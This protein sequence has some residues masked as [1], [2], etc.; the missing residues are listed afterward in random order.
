MFLPRFSLLMILFLCVL[1]SAG[2]VIS[3]PAPKGEPLSNDY[4]VT[5]NGK[6]VPV[7]PVKSQHRDKKYSIAY[8]D[9]E[10]PV[11]VTIKTSRPLNN[12]VVLPYKYG[13]KPSVNGNAATFTT[14]RPFDISFEPTGGDSPLL[15]FSNSLEKDVPQRDDKNVIYFGPGVHN[16]VGGLIKLKSNQTLYIAGGAVVK[17]GIDATGDNI[18]IMG[19][20]II[21]GSDWDHN[22]GPNDFMIN[23]TDCNNLIIKDVILKGS[24]YWTV[25]PQRCDRVLIDHIRLAG[26]RVGNDDGVNPCNSSN[27]TIKNCFFRTDDDAISPKGITRA[28][29]EQTS[30]PVENVLVENCT[31]WVDF[32]NVFRIATESSCPAI[33]NFTAR[34]I[35]VI[36]FPRRKNVQI[37]YLHPTGNMPM[38]NL[39]FENIRIN[40]ESFFNLAKLTPMQPLVGTRS[41]EKPRPNNITLGPGRRGTGSR[42]YGEFVWIHGDGPYIHNVTFRNI[43]TYGKNSTP[44]L[45]P[46]ATLIQGIDEN[47]K[48]SNVIFSNVSLYNK[49]LTAQSPGVKIGPYTNGIT[50]NTTSGQPFVHPGL[51]H[52]AEDLARMKKAVAIRE[53]PVYA[54][55]QR[56]IL[57]PASQYTYTMQGPMSMVGRNPTVGQTVYDSDANAAH[58]NAVMWAITGDKR[59]ADKAIQIVNA[60]SSTLDTITG[61]DA[62]LMAGLGPFKMVNAAE[63]LR[64]TNAGWSE[65]DIKQ[66]EKHFKEVIYPVISHFAPFA[67]GNWDAAAIKTV[68]AIG[69]FC[70][71]RAIYENGLR[72][73]INGCGNGR[74]THYVI[75]EEG[76]AQETGRDQPHTQLGIGL[77]SDC[78]EIAWHQGLDLYSYADNRLLKGFEY[79][80]RYNLGYEVPFTHI[81]DRTGKYEHFKPSTQGRGELRAVYE[82]VYNHYVKRVGLAAPYT[83]QAAEKIRPEGPGRPGADHPGYGT[84]YYTRPAGSGSIQNAPAAPGGLIASGSEKAVMLTWIAAVGAESY[85]VKRAFQRGG[86]YTVIAKQVASTYYTD[87]LVKPGTLYYYTISALNSKGQSGDAFETGIAAGLPGPW[88]QQ[89]IGKAMGNTLYNGESYIIESAGNGLNGRHDTCGYVYQ[90]V[91]GDGVITVRLHPQPSSQFTEVGLMMREAIQDNAAHI[92]LMLFPGQGGSKEVPSWHLRLLSRN[93]AGDTTIVAVMGEPVAAPAVTYGRLTGYYWLR[94]QRKGNDF[95]AFGSYD[96]K[97]WSMIGQ[98]NMTLKKELLTGISVASGMPNSTI[99]QMDN[100]TITK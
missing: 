42:G 87:S 72:Y 58:Q 44:E 8:F 73:Y 47:R 62:V 76:Q 6:P 14:D 43:S 23:A 77:L 24:Y 80:A 4:T 21:D 36:H 15:L 88:Q 60:W 55:Y 81:L 20:G 95:T 19:R 12:L 35:D 41:I 34:N 10:G 90:P 5:V 53:E 86:P 70:N 57:D 65:T 56:F 33:R 32:A 92:S 28:G 68:M 96:G 26:S 98:L 61:R 93:K 67:N 94:V 50:F 63:L 85:Q 46:G 49:P 82:Q 84:L 59:Y 75:N 3:Y 31:F 100:V 71:D 1:V 89:A 40:G 99:V 45:G 18:K 54:G 48:V 27:V 38:E 91:S 2:Q 16:P 52:S 78:S 51:L 39:V 29:G 83:S 66:T 7:Y 22:A 11:T 17:A 13:I 64:Y 79:T 25:V 37:F 97:E 9:F 74:L 30:R 69:V